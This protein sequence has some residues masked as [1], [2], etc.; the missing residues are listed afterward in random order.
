MSCTASPGISR[1]S[2]NTMAVA[3]SS[4]GT[5]TTS[6]RTRYR[7]STPSPRPRTSPVEPC[8][9]EAAAVVVAEVRPVI[10]QRAVPHRGIDLPD[11]GRVVNLPGEIAL[12]VVDDLA[13]LGGIERAPLTNDHVGDDG[14]VHVAL[15]LQLAGI[16]VAEQIV[17]A[18]E[19]RRL[20][21]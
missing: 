17:V 10:L 8:R 19:E 21:P 16:V 7:L 15:V 20:W 13:A 14:V 12:D 5:A 4:E 3:I 1:G 11:R 9:E 2:V 6:R 18:V